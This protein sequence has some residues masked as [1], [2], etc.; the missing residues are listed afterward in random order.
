MVWYDMAL[1][2][3]TKVWFD[4]VT[5]TSLTCYVIVVKH[6]FLQSVV[7]SGLKLDAPQVLSG[8]LPSSSEKEIHQ[9]SNFKSQ[10][11]NE[12]AAKKLFRRKKEV[13]TKTTDVPHVKIS[14]SCFKV[15]YHHSHCHHNHHKNHCHHDQSQFI[16]SLGGDQL[17]LIVH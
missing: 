13:F 7:W 1:L 12:A 9:S 16:I 11:I 4:K 3:V 2:I 14:S 5:N 10:S 8:K 15:N 17:P 6:C